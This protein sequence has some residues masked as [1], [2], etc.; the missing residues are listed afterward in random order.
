MHL[1]LLQLYRTLMYN[2]LQYGSP[3]RVLVQAIS[4][5]TVQSWLHNS[6]FNLLM[7]VI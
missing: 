6:V 4:V 7:V 1:Q 5:G 2:M 3:G